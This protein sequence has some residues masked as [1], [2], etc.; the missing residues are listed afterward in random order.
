[1]VNLISGTISKHGRLDYVVNNAGGQFRALFEH[2]SL[3][4]WNAVTGLNLTGTYLMCR[5]AYKQY[6]KANGGAIVNILIDFT[7]GF[8]GNSHSGAARA[9]V[10]NLTK[11]L[12]VEWAPAGV[13]INSV[14]PVSVIYTDTA[15]ALY[16]EESVKSNIPRIP[17]KRLG[18]PEEISTA[19]C[20][21]LS[22]SAAYITGETIK[23][24]GGISFY[25]TQGYEVPGNVKIVKENSIGEK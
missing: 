10:D 23:V 4:G 13:R 16:G 14:A 17:L 21:L 20:F 15:A 7:R 2:I 24:D 18:T 19:V 22:P 6:M 5:E 11:T 8:P 9:G 1:V 12:A 3:N 25:M